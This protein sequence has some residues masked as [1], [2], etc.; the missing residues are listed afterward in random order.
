MATRKATKARRHRK[1]ASAVQL[2]DTADSVRITG[3][4]N[5]PD[6]VRIYY[7]LGNEQPDPAGEEGDV[8]FKSRGSAHVLDDYADFEPELPSP[9]T[10]N[11]DLHSI[12]EQLLVADGH[13]EKP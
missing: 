5:G 3:C 1:L 13:V 12:A 6:G 10:V 9:G 4:R 2:G 7:E 8:V 11:N